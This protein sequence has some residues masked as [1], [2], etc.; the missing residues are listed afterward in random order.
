MPFSVCFNSNT[1]LRSQKF[2]MH[3]FYLVK[4]FINA[5]NTMYTKLVNVEMTVIGI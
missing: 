1:H 4:S 3:Y 5:V 2:Y